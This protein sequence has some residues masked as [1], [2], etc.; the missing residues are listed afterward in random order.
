MS[1]QTNPTR[2]SLTWLERIFIIFG[3]G[4]MV[5]IGVLGAK[6]LLS[7]VSSFTATATKSY[8]FISRSGGV[9]AYLLLT[10]S[11]LWGLMQSGAI[12]RPII[13]PVLALGMH[14]FLSWA[15]LVMVALHA[16]ILMG[17][18]FIKMEL[19]HLF[20]PFVAPYQPF[21][22]GLGVIGFYLA[23]FLS[24][25]FYARRYIGQKTFRYFHY[26]SYLTFILVTLHSL[27]SGTDSNYLLVLYVLS[28]GAVIN[29]TFWRFANARR[30]KRQFHYQKIS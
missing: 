23:F 11:V 18:G 14:N 2:P 27:G 3:L 9:L 16:L 8:W 7:L 25:S 12:L 26:L 17:D 15:A 6:G 1:T 13:S 22:V 4:M 19:V 28:A 29:L 30:A 21:W 20:I 10:F 5:I 24:L